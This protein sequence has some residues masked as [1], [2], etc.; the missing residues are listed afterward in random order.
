MLT[1]IDSWAITCEDDSVFGFLSG[2][3]NA[4]ENVLGLAWGVGTA[5]TA[6]F[7]PLATEFANQ[8][9]AFAD[10]AASPGAGG[11]C[12]ESFSKWMTD[13]FATKEETLS[14]IE[15]MKEDI[16]SDTWN[17]ISDM[18]NNDVSQELV[19]LRNAEEEYTDWIKGG[20]KKDVLGDT[21]VFTDRLTTARKSLQKCATN[22]LMAAAEPESFEAFKLGALAAGARCVVDFYYVLHIIYSTI[23]DGW[24]PTKTM[25]DDL[26]DYK[27]KIGQW[28]GYFNSAV[29][30]I[31]KRRADTSALVY[32][33]Y[34]GSCRTR[35]RCSRSCGTWP[36][37]GDQTITTSSGT[38]C[39]YQDKAFDLTGATEA[40][41]YPYRGYKKECGKTNRCSD[42]AR[43]GC[44]EDP[45]ESPRYAI[46]R[47]KSYALEKKL[48]EF[49]RRIFMIDFTKAT[50][51]ISQMIEGINRMDAY[52]YNSCVLK[53][54]RACGGSTW[55]DVG[56]LDSAQCMAKCKEKSWCKC[57]TMSKTFGCRL[58]R[59]TISS[60]TKTG[61]WALNK[62]DCQGCELV[63]GH[64]C[65]GY[66][67]TDYN[68]VHDP[69]TC[70]AK[71]QRESWCK[72]ITMSKSIGCR[73]ERGEV[74]YSSSH[75]EKAAMNRDNCEPMVES[76]VGTES[77]IGKL[78][79]ANKALATILRGLEN[80]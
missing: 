67:Y 54:N 60:G 44:D 22:F 61:Y 70:M 73:L 18:I 4:V 72:C 48:E 77:D 6:N 35:T 19:E 23:E 40:R 57:I 9:L 3:D 76:A 45:R 41:T 28:E 2:G 63:Q 36:F 26:E 80:N 69:A 53:K 79:A 66:P 65:G 75:P 25:L 46:I 20:R 24:L 11:S 10:L 64:A 56:F 49:H 14:W 34:E 27:A 1:V 17:L 59:G 8:A 43:E 12:K 33:K 31:N 55:S 71:C 52:V 51:V 16:T 42:V 58:E 21:G 78:E 32:S 38:T 47:S 74:S 50:D 30:E 37:C 68:S 15:L 39:V 29:R 62:A 5:V 7:H 13:T